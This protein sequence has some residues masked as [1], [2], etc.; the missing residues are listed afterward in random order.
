MANPLG[1]VFS[2]ADALKRQLY[3]MLSNPR[4]YASMVAGRT[5]EAAQAADALQ[6]M[7][8]ADPQNPLKITNPQALNQ[9]TQMITSGPL[10]FAP[11]G[12]TAF[13]G[14]PYLFRQFDPMKVGTGEGAQAYG[15]GA[16]YTA[17]ARPVAEEYAR[18]ISRQKMI[19]GTVEGPPVQQMVGNMP[20]QDF[21]AKLDR[22]AANLPPKQA[23][24]AY[25]KLD[26]VERLGLGTN[27]PDIR[28]YVKELGYSKAVQNWVEKELIPKYKPAGYL[29]KGDIPDEILPKFL[30]WDKSLS[31][32]SEDIK[33]IL[34]RRITDVQPTDKFDM[35]GNARLR[36]NRQGQY[37]KT[38]PSPWIMESYDAGGTRA[39]GLSQKDVDRMFGAKDVKDLTGEQIYSRLT[40]QMGSQQAA[41]DYLNSIGIRGIRYLDQASRGE[42]KGTSNFIPFRP[43][44]F[45]IQEIN[46]IP[47]EQWYAK[48]LLDKPLSKVEEA[49]AAWEANPDNKELYE[50]YRKLRL[51]E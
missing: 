24:D 47:I 12:I 34:K 40:Q 23:K 31:Q 18:N 5:Q 33:N 32:Q 28:E 4:D 41:S 13:H 9:L 48:G 26:I 35:G 14:S 7:A 36:D 19:E 6:K 45:K 49:K 10:G 22:Q 38:S 37:D 15:V 20:I 46:D 30:D 39:F 17:E 3:D 44:D 51:G 8:F 50:T 1:T 27:V 21:Y 2:R 11:A 16:G 43:E 25:A 29:Y 42:S